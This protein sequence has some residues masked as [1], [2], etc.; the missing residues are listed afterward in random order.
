[1]SRSE[2]GDT[3]RPARRGSLVV[4]GTGITL[5]HQTTV[6]ALESMQRAERLLYLV[7]DPATEAWIQQLNVTATTL[8]DC[9]GPRKPRIRT[10]EEITD[11]ML[12]SVREGFEVCAAFYGH[13]GVLVQPAHEAV[14]RA[15]REGF[16]A[17][18]LPGISTEACLFADLSV[19]PG[20]YGCQSFEA[21]DFLASRRRFDPSS[22]LILWQVGALGEWS[23]RKRMSCRPERLRALTAVLQR[24]YPAR[25]RVA[26]YQA[27]LFPTCDPTVRWV[28]LGE[29]AR[30]KILPTMTLYVPPKAQR[31][32]L[33]SVVKW[34]DDRV[35]RSS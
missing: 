31:P 16:R 30:E 6:A 12:E 26:L 19:D 17:R 28:A 7:A 3:P 29:L 10:Y 20:E 1:M 24:R 4:V 14:R 2:A 33:A 8:R 22:S 5:V 11:R 13:P 15:R 34:L 23:A 32:P 9:Y 27:A 21:T 25:H 18:M 35:S